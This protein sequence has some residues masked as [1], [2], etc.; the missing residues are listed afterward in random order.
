MPRWRNAVNIS[1]PCVGG[2]VR[3]SAPLTRSTGARTLSTC[4]IG[5][6][7]RY[8]S[9]DCDGVPSNRHSQTSAEYRVW[10][11]L[12]KSQMLPELTIALNRFVW[13]AV[14]LVIYPPQLCPYA[15]K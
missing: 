8:W 10:Y 12:G 13:V 14:Q 1:R 9:S 3:S 2:V 11:T 7:F 5:D 15:N 6:H 4:R